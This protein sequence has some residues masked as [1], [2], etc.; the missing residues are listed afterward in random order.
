[1]EVER[2][3]LICFCLGY[4]QGALDIKASDAK[5]LL[6]QKL[7]EMN[8]PVMTKDEIQY[9]KDLND[10]MGFTL[11]QMGINRKDIRKTGMHKK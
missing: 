9:I 4:I 10:E 3:A 5:I 8:Q 11:M 6:D 7:I 2:K 1:M